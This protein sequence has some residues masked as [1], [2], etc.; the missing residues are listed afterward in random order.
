MQELDNSEFAKALEEAIEKFLAFDAACDKVKEKGICDVV[1]VKC[2]A[3][4]KIYVRK[5]KWLNALIDLIRSVPSA[6]VVES[7]AVE[8]L[9]S[10]APKEPEKPKE[11]TCPSCGMKAPRFESKY[12]DYCGEEL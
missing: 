1:G 4:C 10:E 5:E 11:R 8:P 9:E 7:H 12:C 6:A 2:D 3:S